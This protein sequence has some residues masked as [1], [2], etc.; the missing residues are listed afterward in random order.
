M[1]DHKKPED[2]P[3]DLI[4][5]AEFV[6][7]LE[8]EMRDAETDAPTDEIAQKRL[9]QRLEASTGAEARKA[10][11][12]LWPWAVAAALALG[13]L[14]PFLQ[15]KD[16]DQFKSGQQG[17]PKAG[18]ELSLTMDK[19]DYI[20]SYKGSDAEFLALVDSKEPHD[21]L[22]LRNG[23]SGSWTIP[24]SE[25]NTSRACAIGGEDITDITKK[26]NIIRELKQLPTDVPCLTFPDPSE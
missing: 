17:A 4:S 16:A 3:K 22:W 11:R 24:K 15:E 13:L 1:T 14:L 26:L 18:V 9:W 19:D 2:L 21:V 10:G 25:V 8:A 7:L 6:A 5:D 20:I 12:K 23:P